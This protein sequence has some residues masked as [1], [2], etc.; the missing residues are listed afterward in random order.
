MKNENK[1]KPTDRDIADF[2]AGLPE[3]R[4]A[5]TETLVK[6]MQDISGEPPVLWIEYNY[7]S[8]W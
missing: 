8:V 2:I 1:T 5:D 3:N 6:I 4:Q 7:L